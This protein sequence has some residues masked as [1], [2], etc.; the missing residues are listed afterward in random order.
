MVTDINSVARD[1]G[2]VTYN[3]QTTDYY[4]HK[5]RTVLLLKRYEL[6]DHG[7]HIIFAQPDTIVS[8]NNRK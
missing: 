4:R 2:L 1:C 3:V 7:L 6:T 5:P 8:P